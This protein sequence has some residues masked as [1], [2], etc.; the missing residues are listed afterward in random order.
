[1]EPKM[2]D[3]PPHMERYNAEFEKQ[4]GQVDELQ[5]YILKGH[6]IIESALDNIINL[7][8]FHPEHI[9]DAR[10]GFV[11]KV[12]MARA[13]GLRK[14]KASLWNL[15]LSI[16]AVRNEIAHQ[17]A[18][19]KRER[20]MAQLRRLYIAELEDNAELKEAHKN[21]PDELIAMM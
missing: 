2:A 18:G 20:K 1:M 8:F 15:I 19:E 4:L 6:L 14:H 12:N 21:Y 5:Q 7:I 11:H 9:H 17:L 3:V 10:F 13:Y 16:N